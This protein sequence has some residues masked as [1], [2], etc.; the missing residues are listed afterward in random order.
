[1]RC[2]LR[3]ERGE[4]GV[5]RARVDDGCKMHRTIIINSNKLLIALKTIFH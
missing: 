1:M 4:D 2:V 3:E 5:A